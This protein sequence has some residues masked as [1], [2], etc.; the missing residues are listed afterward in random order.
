MPSALLSSGDFGKFSALITFWGEKEKVGE[1]SQGTASYVAYCKMI[2]SKMVIARFL[3]REANMQVRGQL[4]PGLSNLLAT[5]RCIMEF[6]E[7]HDTTDT[8]DFLPAPTCYGLGTGK[9]V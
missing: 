2:A 7:R 4:L 5:S 8:T 3:G 1:G 6:G 9:L